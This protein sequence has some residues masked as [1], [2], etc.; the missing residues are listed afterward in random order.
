LRSLFRWLGAPWTQRERALER[1]ELAEI[2][3]EAAA[4]GVLS[5][6]HLRAKVEEALVRHWRHR[7]LL[8]LLSALVMLVAAAS[9][10]AAFTTNRAVDAI[11]IAAT[12]TTGPLALL[13][14]VRRS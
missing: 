5:S 1:N 7:A 12:A 8:R 14:A 9:L 3:G 6:G 13:L 10:L 4:R 11:A 2:K